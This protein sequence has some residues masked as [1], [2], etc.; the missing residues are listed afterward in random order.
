M[1]L[2]SLL[3]GLSSFAAA[4]EFDEW[5]ANIWLAKTFVK[6]TF[7]VINFEERILAE[8]PATVANVDQRFLFSA[9]FKDHFDAS[10]K[11]L[12]SGFQP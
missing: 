4:S 11:C 2:S 9:Q 8:F 10:T 1:K 6:K 7:E 12:Y 5:P 3:L